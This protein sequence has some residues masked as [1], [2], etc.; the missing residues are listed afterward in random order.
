MK[1]KEEI[2]KIVQESRSTSTDRVMIL[3]VLIDIR[4]LL[5]RF[6]NEQRV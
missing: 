4:D 5:A 3:E 2:V 6:V 1:T